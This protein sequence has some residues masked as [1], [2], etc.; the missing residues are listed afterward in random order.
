MAN[1]RSDFDKAK[2]E[3]VNAIIDRLYTNPK[4]D[5]VD[6]VIPIIIVVALFSIMLF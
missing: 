3:L 6:Y 5:W 1:P 2:D 4:I